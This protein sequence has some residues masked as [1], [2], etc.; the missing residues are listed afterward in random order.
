MFLKDI[1]KR[2]KSS[3]QT[4]FNQGKYMGTNAPFGYLKDPNNKNQLIIDARYVSLIKRIFELAKNGLGIA[5]IRKIL[6]EEKIPR[7]AACACDNGANFNR[8]FDGNEENR[9]TWSNNSV[10]GILRNPTYAGHLGGYKRVSLSMKSKKRAGIPMEDW[11]IIENTHEAI[12]SQ[13]DFDIVQRLMTSRRKSK[14]GSSGYDNIFSGIIKCAD[15]GYAMR[16]TVANRK[17]KERAVENILYTC[18]NY[19]IY[20]RVACTNH[21]I[22]A[23]LLHKVVLEDILKHSKMALENDEEL[24]NSV[25]KSIDFQG[26]QKNSQIKKDLKQAEKRLAEV[27]KLFSQLYEDSVSKKITERNYSFMSK[28]YEAEQLELDAKIENLKLELDEESA[29]IENV[30]LWIEQMKTCIEIE[31]LSAPL[32]NSLIDRITVSEPKIIDNQKVQT[33]N[34]YYKFVGCIAT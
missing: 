26:K 25:L 22:E 4:R 19:T 23:S 5:K 8:F 9:Y 16:T 30:N 24:L 32:L 7:P 10:R 13:D 27:D 28:K 11:Q 34:I 14:P 15:C 20:G 31:E 18:N 21:N 33:V 3:R 12:V 17:K 6:T 1:S 2:I 29:T